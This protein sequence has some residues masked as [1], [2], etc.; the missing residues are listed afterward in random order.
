[1]APHPNELLN[2]CRATRL[3]AVPVLR[4]GIRD[5]ADVIPCGAGPPCRAAAAA[6]RMAACGVFGSSTD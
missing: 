1:M 5:G 3:T 6:E 2:G 4:A